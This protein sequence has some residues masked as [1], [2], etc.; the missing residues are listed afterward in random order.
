VVADGSRE[1]GAGPSAA[2]TPSG[3][4]ISMGVVA[5]VVGMSTGAANVL[6]GGFLLAAAGVIVART[7]DGNTNSA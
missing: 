5:A 2:L 1:P 7:T 4:L 3:A 6:L